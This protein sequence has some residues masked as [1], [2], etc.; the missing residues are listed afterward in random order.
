MGRP[1]RS[2]GGGRAMGT[3]EFRSVMTILIFMMRQDAP[4]AATGCPTSVVTRRRYLG[5]DDADVSTSEALRAIYTFIRRLYIC[6]AR[7]VAYYC[8]SSIPPCRAR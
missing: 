7:A 3:G 1:P 2:A 4:A 6:I 8:S 5:S